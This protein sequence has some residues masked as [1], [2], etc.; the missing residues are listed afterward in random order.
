MERRGGGLPGHCDASNM[1]AS[2]HARL[3]PCRQGDGEFEM[4]VLSGI[5]WFKVTERYPL[6]GG[7]RS[8]KRRDMRRGARLLVVDGPT[9]SLP[10]ARQQRAPH[11]S[12]AGSASAPARPHDRPSFEVA[13][14]A[15]PQGS[16]W[17]AYGRCRMEHCS[18]VWTGPT[19][20]E[21][22]APTPSAALPR[23]RSGWT[24]CLWWGARRCAT[25]RCTTSSS[26]GGGRAAAA[27]KAAGLPPPRCWRRVQLPGETWVWCPKAAS[28]PT[29]GTTAPVRCCA[30]STFRRGLDRCAVASCTV[31]D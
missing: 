2:H 30:W 25:A 26:S 7:E 31:A 20:W 10:G 29:F 18:S 12:A 1:T 6:D 9:G 13:P 21:A 24:R 23:T 5:L 16:T 3:G 14:L 27:R 8:F 4:S 28:T 17:A 15:R 22:V 19:P 11:R